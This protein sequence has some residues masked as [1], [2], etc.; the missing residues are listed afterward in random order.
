MGVISLLCGLGCVP[1]LLAICEEE[2]AKKCKQEGLIA[3]LAFWAWRTKADASLLTSREMS[4][5]SLL[6]AW[7]SCVINNFIEG[8]NDDNK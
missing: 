1:I 3:P 2:G 8:I 5:R 4:S 7:I 6:S